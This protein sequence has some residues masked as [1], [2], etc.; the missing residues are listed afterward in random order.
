MHIAVAEGTPVVSVFG[1][2][3]PIWIGPYGR[4]DAVVAADVSCAGCYLRRLRD[5][6]ND[7]LCMRE[8][9]AEA[10]IARVRRMLTNS[11]TEVAAV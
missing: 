9:T 5:C 8:V 2:T 10:V 4:P 1:P 3:N 7:H 11:P 6:P